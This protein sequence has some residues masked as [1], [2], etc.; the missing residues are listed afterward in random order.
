[1]I[2][3]RFDFVS[4][5]E[6]N[7][8]ILVIAPGVSRQQ[9]G[10]LFESVGFAVDTC[11]D[12]AGGA[13]FL[14]EFEYDACVFS[15]ED[16]DDA[17]GTSKALEN[18]RDASESTRILVLLPGDSETNSADV[19]RLGAD[20]VMLQP[21]NEDELI[22]RVRS[23]CRRK[24][25]VPKSVICVD[26]MTID[27]SRRTVERS[28]EPIELT[29]REFVLLEFL[30]FRKGQVVTREEIRKHVY[31]AID[32]VSSSNVVDVYIGYLRKKLEREGSPKILHTRRGHGYILGSSEK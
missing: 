5:S 17:D 22:E 24:Y 12:K 31:D 32:Q 7:M 23:L 28:G 20:D 13:R 11:V 26:D 30:A 25:S 9:F 10:A 27:C 4:L 14:S 21:P 15:V 2:R 1:M 8:R 18:L 3:L 16:S 19:L 29:P 6:S